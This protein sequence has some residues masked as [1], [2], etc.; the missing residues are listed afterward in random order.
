MKTLNITPQ[1]IKSLK[2]IK[3]DLRSAVSSVNRIVI[4]KNRKNGK[5]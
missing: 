3:K 2:Y 5:G 1:L 4:A